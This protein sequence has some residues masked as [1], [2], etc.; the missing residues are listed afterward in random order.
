MI[1]VDGD[2]EDVL[3]GIDL[4][5]AA[6]THTYGSMYVTVRNDGARESADAF[7][8]AGDLIYTYDNLTG[9]DKDD[10]QLVPIGLATG[11][12]SWTTSAGSRSATS[13][14]SSSIAGSPRKC[15][16]GASA[17]ICAIRLM[18][19]SS[20]GCAPATTR[21]VVITHLHYDHVGNFDRFPKAR[22]HLQEAEVAFATGKYMHHPFLS[23]A[24]EVE[25]VV[26][27]VRLNYR[28]RV[29][30]HSGDTELAPGF[31]LHLAGGHSAGLQF[32]SV[33]M[34]RGWLVL[35]SD[36]T[37]YTKGPSD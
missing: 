10:P 8:L 26:G 13:A 18:R 22:F 11:S 4:H 28:G 2:L 27:M 14:R 1:A 32:V 30:F 20:S 9:L 6:D 23:H 36:V 33:H 15:L 3:P 12:Q 19:S 5:L 24:F 16:L 31:R 17:P 34:R 21:T 37:H 29:I 25:D 35:A 7:I